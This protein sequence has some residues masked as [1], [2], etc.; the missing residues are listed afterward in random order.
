[1]D[2]KLT[3]T[4][5]KNAIETLWDCEEDRP[6]G[7]GFF[8]LR[9]DWM[10]TAKHI[11]LTDEL[12]KRSL[13]VVL[14]DHCIVKGK[15]VF[16]HPEIDISIIQFDQTTKCNTPLFPSYYKFTGANGL[17]SV[18]YSPSLKDEDNRPNLFFN[19]IESFKIEKRGRRS[20]D[21]ETIVFKA[22]YIEGGFSGGPILG[23]GGG[24][25]GIIIENFVSENEIYARA[26]SILPLMKDLHFLSK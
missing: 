1:M 17:I 25:V 11:T 10:V 3:L 22:P 21:E 26:T 16:I 24:V 6:I 19:R 8:F 4:I 12:N 9:S 13:A 20:L 14:K 18:G 23:E 2:K 5:D 15:I 7:T